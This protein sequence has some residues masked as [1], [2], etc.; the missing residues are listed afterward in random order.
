[1]STPTTKEAL[2]AA[3]GS[4]VVDGGKRWKIETRDIGG[5]FACDAL[6]LDPEDEDEAKYCV[7]DLWRSESGRAERVMAKAVEL[8]RGLLA[9]PHTA[10]V[11]RRQPS[12]AVQFCAQH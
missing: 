12:R 6:D 7:M 2:F 5:H 11:R 8:G 4:I 3:S 9:S 1:M 10:K